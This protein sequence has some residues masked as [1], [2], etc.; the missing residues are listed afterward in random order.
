M[1][2]FSFLS[3]V[4]Q[5]KRE[6]EKDNTTPDPTAAG[7]QLRGLRG[8]RAFLLFIDSS[9]E[10]QT[11]VRYTANRVRQEKGRIILLKVITEEHGEERMFVGSLLRARRSATPRINSKRQLKTCTTSAETYRNLW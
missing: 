1:S 5:W 10:A 11:A 2:L 4:F 6:H 8:E 9:A 3:R 7:R